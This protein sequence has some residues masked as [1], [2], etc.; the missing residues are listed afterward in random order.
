MTPDEQQDEDNWAGEGFRCPVCARLDP[1]HDD[2]CWF[3]PTPKEDV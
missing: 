3:P 2:G 1:N